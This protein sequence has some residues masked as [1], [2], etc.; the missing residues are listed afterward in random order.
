MVTPDIP[1]TTFDI[2]LQPGEHYFGDQDTTI[3][4]V[5]GSCVAVVLWSPNRRIGGMCHYMLPARPG[6][7]GDREPLDGRYADEAIELLFQEIA[8]LKARPDEFITKLFGGGNMFI[9]AGGGGM[10]DVGTKNVNA[11]RELARRRGLN[12][13]AEHLGGTGHRNVI[14]VINSGDVWVR[15]SATSQ[16]CQ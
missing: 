7:R 2:F 10:M 12:V 15:F 14:F 1:E 3:R 11:A 5:L 16:V 4:T 9:R 13:V 6:G 8:R